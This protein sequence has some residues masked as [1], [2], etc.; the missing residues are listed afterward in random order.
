LNS[1][2][3]IK[4]KLKARKLVTWMLDT[5]LKSAAVANSVIAQIGINPD[6]TVKLVGSRLMPISM[7]P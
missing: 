6:S 5:L 2:Y 3:L 7:H 4:L 1:F